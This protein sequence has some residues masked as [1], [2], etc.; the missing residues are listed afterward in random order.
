MLSSA[1][2]SSIQCLFAL[3]QISGA[4]HDDHVGGSGRPTSPREISAKAIKD[5][6][7]HWAQAATEGCVRV[8]AT[9]TLHTLSRTI[10]STIFFYYIQ[11]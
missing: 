4:I 9:H 10:I 2:E 11:L 1:T 3:V 5:H 6:L 8:R 7:L